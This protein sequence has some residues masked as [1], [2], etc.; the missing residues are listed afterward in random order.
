MAEAAASF[1][2]RFSRC[3]DREGVPVAALPSGAADADQLRDLYTALVRT[4]AFD[5][6]AIALQRTGRLGTYASSLGQEA[7]GVGVAS[8]MHNDDVLVPS[9]REHG[10]QL[11]RGVSPVELFL[12]WG[13]DERGSDFAGPRE[14]FPISVP[15]GSHA[16]HAAGV[17]MAFRLRREARAVVCIFG[18]GATSKGDVA[19]ALNMAGAMAVTGRFC[20]Q[21]QWMGNF[22]TP[23]PPKC[24]R[25]I[26]AK[27]DRRRY[28]RRTSRR[29]RRR[30]GSWRRCRSC[31]TSAR[32]S[33]A[34]ADRGVDL[35]PR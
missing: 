26:G 6:K 10:A 18:D 1:E 17:A 2:I 14:D 12:Y 11:W 32:G 13:G 33:R 30:R 24:R 7:V 27:G 16:P 15:I 4:R 35:P 21:Q 23:Q 8:A 29:Q 34:G 20:H 28:P 25:D 9:F 3:I 22:G 31:S 19:E 5:A